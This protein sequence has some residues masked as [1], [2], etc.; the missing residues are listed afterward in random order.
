MT[1]SES[2]IRVFNFVMVKKL[3]VRAFSTG[4]YCR[5]MRRQVESVRLSNMYM[6][7]CNVHTKISG[8]S[9]GE[10]CKTQVN[11]CLHVFL[12]AGEYSGDM[13]GSAL[14]TALQEQTSHCV[15]K[16]SGVGGDLMRSKVMA[17]PTRVSTARH[18]A[19]AACA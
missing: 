12:V 5:I 18:C 7:L 4:I 1:F 19:A 9:N 6:R 10:E 15:I 11:E 17:V 16:F 14:M 8:T 3:L 13:L 2:A